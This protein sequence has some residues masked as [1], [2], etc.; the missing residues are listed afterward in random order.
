MDGIVWI[1][2]AALFFGGGATYVARRWFFESRRKTAEAMAEEILTKARREAETIRHEAEL[3]AVGAAQ[4]ARSEWEKE[5]AHRRA[6]LGALEG[7]LAERMGAL[8]RRQEELVHAERQQFIREKELREREDA[9]EQSKAAQRL[10]LERISGLSAQAAREAL[11]EAVRREAGMEAGRLA[12]R[13]EDEA[14]EHAEIAAKHIVVSAIER[15][16]CEYATESSIAVVPLPG[17]EMKG[18]IIGKEGRNIRSFEA[19]TGVDLIVDEMPGAVLVSSFDPLR[20]EIGRVAMERLLADGRIHPARIEEVVE[21]TR[22]DIDTI[23]IEEAGKVIF[24]LGISAVHPEIVKLLGR[25]RFRTSYGQNNLLH[26]KEA[27]NVCRIMATELGLDVPLAKRAALLHDIGKA[28]SHEEEGSHAAIGAELARRYN[29][30]PRVVNAIA[31]H[32]GEVEPATPEAVLVVAA[33]A[34]SA[35]RPGARRESAETYVKRLQALEK[36][37]L[38]FP[39]V[40]KAYAIQAGREIRIIVQENRLTDEESAS[41]ARDIAKKIEQELTYPGQVK[42]TV[43]RETRFVEIAR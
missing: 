5:E 7:R 37:A 4:T 32:H 30:D 23:M 6:D 20:R 25:L 27:A 22:A 41:V 19:A 26:S 13:I 36:L 16:A 34:V 35:A 10:E 38:S 17:D 21:K 40:D 11:L 15:G 24:D 39:G 18:R 28:V 9:L 12:K 33:E 31:A 1:S 14:R 42:V 8:D 29:E 3:S 2:G 43:I